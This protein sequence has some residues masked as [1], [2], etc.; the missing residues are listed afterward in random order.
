MNLPPTPVETLERAGRI[1]RQKLKYV[2]L[3]NV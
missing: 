3:G 1:A 2:H